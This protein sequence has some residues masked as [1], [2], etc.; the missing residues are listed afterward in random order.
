MQKLSPY[1]YFFEVNPLNFE[2]GGK[3]MASKV[4]KLFLLGSLMTSAFMTIVACDNFLANSPASSNNITSQDVQSNEPSVSVAPSSSEE[5]EPVVLTGITASSKKENYEW[6]EQVELLVTANYSDGTSQTISEYTVEGFDSQNPGTQPIT[7]KYGE[8]TA[9][10]NVVVKERVNLFPKNT[11][12]N[13][14]AVQAITAEFPTPVGYEEW[15]TSEDIEQDGTHFFVATTKDEGVPGEN[16]IEDQY[17]SLL[18]TAEWTVEKE[19]DTYVASKVEGDAT[20]EFST[21]EGVFSL[22]VNQYVLYPDSAMFGSVLEQAAYLKDGGKIIFGSVEEGVIACSLKDGKFA[23]REV[24]FQKGIL[25]QIDHD[26]IRFTLEKTGSRWI[27][28][29]VKGRK[30]GSTGVGQ[31]TWD[32]GSTEWM[33]ITQGSNTIIMNNEKSY[34]RFAYNPETGILTTVPN[35]V[36]TKLV[37]PSVISLE[38]TPLVYPTDITLGGKEEIGVGKQ[39]A[40]SVKTIPSNANQLNSVVWSSSNEEIATVDQKGV[41]K[42]LAL[43]E[44]TITATT[45]SKGRPLVA[46]YEL[47]IVEFSGDEWTIMLYVCGSNLESQYGCASEDI[48]EILKIGGQPEDI[49]IIIETGGSSRWTNTKI[50]ANKLCRFHVENKNIV[51][52]EKLTKVNMG[53]E[54]TLESYLNWGIQNYPADKYGVIFWNHGGALDGVCFDDYGGSDSIKANE[55]VN[56]MGRVFSANNIAD[57]F[58]FVGYD[59]CLMQVQD[60]AE[61]NSPYFKYMVTSEET[62]NGDGWD[63]EAWIDDLYANKPTEDILTEICD[64]FVRSYGTSGNDQTLSVLD[65]SYAPEYLATW[66]AFA[67]AIKTKAKSNISAFRNI[68]K[69]AK[70]FYGVS[71]YGNIDAYDFL[72]KL[73]AKS[74]YAAYAEEIAAAQA[75]FNQFVI[76]NARGRSAGNAYGLCLHADMG[77]T[78]Y[79]ASETNFNT[80]RSIFTNY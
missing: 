28:R 2:K 80:W 69:S 10:L 63:Y 59:A 23:T 50:D 16:S 48:G 15:T 67:G 78:G 60:I 71:D 36:G 22:R 68:L 34:G 53:K 33:V 58:E 47:D 14:L 65:L 52:D 64:G 56:V 57:K 42:G 25:K 41:V 61:K 9:T 73:K 72:D 79:P 62:E 49:N 5:P 17:A 7:V 24:E 37:Y 55:L 20:L 32:E 54:S 6:G 19:N 11:L 75:A 29:D 8:Y 13:F 43:G 74:D 21:K 4:K 70:C 12:E 76:H 3:Y 46:S 44:V 35:V 30:L 66:E 40:L 45:K 18:K 38:E 77:Y 51:L 27:M 31:L 39:A 26:V 1:I